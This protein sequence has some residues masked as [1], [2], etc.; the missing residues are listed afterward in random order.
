MFTFVTNQTAG[1]AGADSGSASWHRN[2]HCWLP[3][4]LFHHP[5]PLDSNQPVHLY[6]CFADHFEPLRMGADER[7][8]WERVA[9]WSR[10]YGPLV[11]QFRNFEGRPAQHTFFYPAEEY[12]PR[13]LDELKN[14]CAAGYGDVEIHLHHDHDSSQQFTDTLETFIARLQSHGF[15][16]NRERRNRFG[17]IHG[18]WCLN[19]SRRDGRWCGLN[20]ESG[21]LCRLGCYADFTFPSAPSETQPAMANAIYYSRDNPAR[22]KS[23]NRGRR[24]RVGVL[25]DED[26]LCLVTGPLGFDFRRRKLGLL[27]RIENAEIG[28]L[29]ADA[30]RCRRWLRLGARVL[31]AP[32]HVFVKVHSHGALERLHDAV[33]GERAR[34]MYRSLAALQS[35]SLRLHFVTAFEMWQTIRALEK[36]LSISNPQAP[37]VNRQSSSVKRQLSETGP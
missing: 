16:Q 20:N 5:E 23:H 14:L 25:P 15:L 9:R 7:T 17:F 27:P 4:Y 37:A 18:N 33:L 32:N 6:F 19:N 26:E 31:G 24:A 12:R 10:E 11:D 30:E 13:F 36:G 1:P 35:E 22:P 8:G 29:P 21:L 3:D 2:I 34:L 28:A